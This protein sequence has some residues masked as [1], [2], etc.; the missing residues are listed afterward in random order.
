VAAPK[1]AGKCFVETADELQQLPVRK[2][3]VDHGGDLARI[4]VY[5]LD[6]VFDTT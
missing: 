3:D 4:S 1:K 6:L 5:R 2:R